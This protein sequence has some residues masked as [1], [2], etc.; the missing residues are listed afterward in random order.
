MTHRLNWKESNA[1]PTTLFHF[2]WQHISTG[3]DY[4]NLSKIP[5]LKQMVNH[6]EYHPTISNKLNL[7]INLM[8]FCE[9][10]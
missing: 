8:K 1:N 9:V 4:N 10:I 2:K 7:F 6:L 5:S 3:L